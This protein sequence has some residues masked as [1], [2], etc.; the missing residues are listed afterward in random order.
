MPLRRLLILL[1][2]LV[3]ARLLPAADAPELVPQIGHSDDY[4]Y[5][6]YSPDG[7]HLATLGKDGRVLVWNLRTQLIELRIA[8]ARAGLTFPLVS[9]DNGWLLLE[10]DSRYPS[11]A[12]LWS[13]RFGRKVCNLGAFADA[14]RFSFHHDGAHLW[15][16]CYGREGMTHLQKAAY[17]QFGAETRAAKSVLQWVDLETRAVERTIPNLTGQVIGISPDDTLAVTAIYSPPD[18]AIPHGAEIEKQSARGTTELVLWDLATG[19]ELRRFTGIEGYVTAQP[20]YFPCRF[21][22]DGTLLGVQ[23]YCHRPYTIRVWNTHTGALVRTCELPT[24]DQWSG[25]PPNFAFTGHNTQLTANARAFRQWSL[26]DPAPPTTPEPYKDNWAGLVTAYRPDG[27][28]CLTANRAQDPLLFRDTTLLA[29]V[30][31]LRPVLPLPFVHTLATHP[32]GG[33]LAV[34]GDGNAIPLWD[35][36]QGRVT[37]TL[38]LPE[39]L[40]ATAAA[41]SPD[42]KTLL[43]AAFTRTRNTI[44]PW[45]ENAYTQA[46]MCVFDLTTGA[47]VQTFSA[48]GENYVRALA[49][50]PDGRLLASAG[51]DQQIWLWDIATG[52]VLQ[53]LVTNP[54]TSPARLAFTPDGT[55]LAVLSY[56][57]KESHSTYTTLWDLTQTPP[58]VC[59]TQVDT[60]GIPK[61]LAVSPDSRW[62]AILHSKPCGSHG[63]NDYAFLDLVVRRADDGREVWRQYLEEFGYVIAARTLPLL[64]FTPDSATLLVGSRDRTFTLWDAATG[65][66]RGTRI[67]AGLRYVNALCCLGAGP[68]TRLA[69]ATTDGQITLWKLADVLAQDTPT[70]LATL[71]AAEDGRWIATTPGGYYDCSLEAANGLVWR[72]DGNVLPF[73]SFSAT[74]QRPDILKKSLAGEDI[75]NVPPIDATQTPPVVTFMSPKYASEI[76]PDENP[77][78]KLAVTGT[79]PIAHVEITVN[80]QPLPPA[81]AD[82]L[83]IAN[84]TA[85]KGVIPMHLP[86]PPGAPR[87]RIR[88][89]AYDTRGFKSAPTELAL[90][91]PGVK[92]QPGT[93]WVLAVG[94]NN[95]PKLPKGVQLQMAAPDAQAL[96]R[97]FQAQDGVYAGVSGVLLT[98][99]NASLSNLKLA[100]REVKDKA[101]ENDTVV[102]FISGHG[103][104]DAQGNYYFP[105][106][107]VDLK[108]IPATALSW[109][110]FHAALREVRAKRVLVLA[111]TCQ[112]GGIM[113]SASLNSDVLANKLNKEGHRLVFVACAGNE[114]SLERDEWGHGA[115]TKA[116]LD[117]FAGA[118][119][120]NK[121]Q[122]IS[123]HELKDYVTARVT[124]LTGNRQHP[125]LPFLDQFEPE[126][127]LG[128][129]VSEK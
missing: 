54:A 18:D 106:N 126:A 30:A 26:T 10:H 1:F 21:S 75:A 85:T 105:T 22:A 125:Q 45:M 96:S 23:P 34:V 11:N 57:G 33:L 47:I 90:F 39:G 82:K 36:A 107:E 63:P 52:T 86:L 28:V 38:M 116:I 109:Q 13:L 41:F 20:D 55:R 5:M 58:T 44:N 56:A 76:T 127:V 4:V 98:D 69:A 9:A 77:E 29:A 113:G 97:L 25:N 46:R 102:I 104:Q 122:L 66:R 51:D 99:A 71:L 74:Y 112:S 115:F 61:A 103:L 95:Y 92:E 67:V 94:I 2:A 53:K 72:M 91:R 100:L 87:L 114:S 73:D 81:L 6:T 31:Q 68:Q 110:D 49:F 70:P 16:W 3:V 27:Q 124:A 24:T 79:A 88:A 7:T 83:V 111:D 60:D 50:S 78:I 117:A 43:S 108:N 128:K 48:H 14:Y 62:V 15:A 121:D 19:T 42:G 65:V 64:T 118:A 120:T 12:E 80:G 8:I 93:L 101:A 123:F 32:N 129:V 89:V 17:F 59:F 119:D 40:W 84:P 35:V 37:R